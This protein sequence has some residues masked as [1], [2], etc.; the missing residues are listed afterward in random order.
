MKYNGSRTGLV[1]S[2]SSD[3][4]FNSYL[5]LHQGETSDVTNEANTVRLSGFF[6]ESIVRVPA[7]LRK[8]LPQGSI[9]GP[10]LFV[11]YI[12]RSQ[13]NYLLGSTSLYVYAVSGTT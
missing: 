2:N 8:C 11:V 7:S 9:I 6:V 4:T 5:T 3:L 10:L 12:N 13:Y 1:K